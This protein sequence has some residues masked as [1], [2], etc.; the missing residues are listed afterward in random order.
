MNENTGGGPKITVHL[1]PDPNP[2]ESDT[3]I[4]RPTGIATVLLS[5]LIVL[6]TSYHP[7]AQP[8]PAYT[9]VLFLCCAAALMF[10]ARAL[11]AV[12]AGG[13]V[14]LVGYLLGGMLGGAQLAPIGGVYALSCVVAIAASALLLTTRPSLWLAL[15]PAA[16]YGLLLLQ[17]RDALLSVCALLTFPAAGLLAHATMNNRPRVSVICYTSVML[18]LCACLGVSLLWY[19]SGAPMS[20]SAMLN[21]VKTLRSDL[22]AATTQSE[23]A[24]LWDQALE[25]TGIR[26]TD[27]IE[28]IIVLLFNMLPALLIGIVNVLSYAAQLIGNRLYRGL[29]LHALITR[30]SQLFSMSVAA[31]VLYLLASIISLFASG[32]SL[33]LAVVEN[34]RL[35][36]LPG[37]CVVGFWKLIA[38]IYRRRSWGFL[39]FLIAITLFLPTLLLLCLAISGALTTLM[40]PIVARMLLQGKLP[41][42]GGS[43]DHNDNNDKQ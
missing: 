35:I 2:W 43:N 19:H 32:Q 28:S 25:G 21:A 23:L 5:L 27:L 24:V 3:P 33:F 15:I 18:G 17:C 31:A 11:P 36:L 22:I 1:L 9:A 14:L 30:S 20:V 26:A 29:G 7:L 6:C 13:A 40:R 12:L 38:D 37:M 42:D 39:I 4:P 8:A 34:L 16:A 41:Q 10:L